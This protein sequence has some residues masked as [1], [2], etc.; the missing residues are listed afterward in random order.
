MGYNQN[1]VASVKQSFEFK[2]DRAIEASNA[3][4]QKLHAEIPELKEIDDELSLTG[5]EIGQ[6]ML[7]G[8]D[9]GLTFEEVRAKNLAL[10]RKRAEVL[11]AH[12]YPSDITALKF[13]CGKCH[14][15]G[16]TDDGKMCDCMR[17]ALAKAAFAASGLG[18]L[19]GRNTFDSFDLSY[20]GAKS[21]ATYKRMQNNL[22]MMKRY[23][24]S[25]D[26]KTSGDLLLMGGTG[27]GKTHLS[28]AL[29]EQVI[30]R[31]FDVYYT[32]AIDLIADFESR[33]FGNASAGGETDG[34]TERYFTCDLLIIDDL[35]TE[36]SNQFTSSCLYNVMNAR[37]NK[38]LSTVISTNLTAG[39]ILERYWDRI[40]SRLLGEYQVLTFEGEDIRKQKLRRIQKN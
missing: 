8:N 31:G 33:R 15:T 29:A 6:C 18:N 30:R 12:G 34:N 38:G 22:E 16:Y 1:T 3:I 19:I 14:D 26:A 11:S 10:Q 32:G 17:L 27:L 37:L 7:G 39:E 40:T 20:Y 2:H 25:F 21:S 23:A 28:T 9:G 24:A 5:I 4:R 35:G 13:E 36:I